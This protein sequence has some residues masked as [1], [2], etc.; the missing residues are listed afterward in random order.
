LSEQFEQV[1]SILADHAQ[2]QGALLP[3]LHAIMRSY[4]YIPGD[5]LGS[6]AGALSL[7]RAEV[8]G[9]VSFYHDFRSEPAAPDVL[10]ICRAEACQAV[11]ARQL[12]TH[13]KASLKLGP[14]DSCH[15]RGITLEA[16]YCLGNCACGPSVS[17]NEQLHAR[18]TPEKFDQL[19]LA[20]DCQRGK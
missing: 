13:A 7:S 14:G 10:K 6:I 18:V 3:V 12:E 2:E 15:Q 5:A 4:G 9:V 1:D 19:M 20:L 11:G 17:I 16:V 8:S